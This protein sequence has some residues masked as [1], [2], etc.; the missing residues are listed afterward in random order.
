M[1]GLPFFASRLRLGPHGVVER[2]PLGPLNELESQG[3]EVNPDDN[4]LARMCRTHGRLHLRNSWALTLRH[5][6]V[7]RAYYCT[8]EKLSRCTEV[9]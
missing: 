8:Y 2:L 5:S 3:L 1:P 6:S 4:V 9:G 7:L